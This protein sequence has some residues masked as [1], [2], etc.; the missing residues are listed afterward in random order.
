[1]RC[2]MHVFLFI[3]VNCITEIYLFIPLLIFI[4]LEA[5]QYPTYIGGWFLYC[6][7]LLRET[8]LSSRDDNRFRGRHSLFIF[9]P[10]HLHAP[11]IV[12]G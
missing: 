9:S 8:G 12:N 10:G 11:L 7:L 6:E 2:V 1:M 4:S 5:I 3:S